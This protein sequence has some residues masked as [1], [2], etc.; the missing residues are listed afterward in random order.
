M[1]YYLFR[2]THLNPLVGTIQI[3]DKYSLK[4]KQFKKL[5]Y[6]NA[7]KILIKKKLILF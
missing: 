7:I 4:T 2:T 5:F 1:L 6:H 3:T